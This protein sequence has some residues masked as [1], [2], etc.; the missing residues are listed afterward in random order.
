M[1]TNPYFNHFSANNEQSLL[2]GLVDEAI[3]IHG[4]D[5]FYLPRTLINY[6]ELLGEDTISEYNSNYPIEMYIKTFSGF[7]GD[8]TFLS[9]FGL[10]IRDQVKLEISVPRFATVLN[11]V[12]TRPQEGDLIYFPLSKAIFTIVFTDNRPVFYAHGALQTYTITCEMFEYS[13]ETLNTGIA[14][15]DNLQTKYSFETSHT[16]NGVVTTDVDLDT[17]PNDYS[18]ENSELSDFANNSGFINRNDSSNP[19]GI[20]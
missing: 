15:V 9:K 2:Q 7:E 8:G 18:S 16:A 14:F 17:K 10:D 5:V 12:R 20:V 1:T 11:G 4:M 6:N 3:Q 19:F 13:S